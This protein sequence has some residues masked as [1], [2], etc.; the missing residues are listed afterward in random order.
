MTLQHFHGAAFPVDLG[1]AGMAPGSGIIAADGVDLGQGGVSRREIVVEADGFEQQ[2]QGFI[3]TVFHAIQLGKI[4]EGIGVA[5]LA[6]DPRALLVH[7]QARLVI[8][9][10]SDDFFLPESHLIM[11]AE[12]GKS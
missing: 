10:R 9:S 12:R 11:I 2:A 8:E 4:G 7:V 1:L 3:L 5:R 6:S